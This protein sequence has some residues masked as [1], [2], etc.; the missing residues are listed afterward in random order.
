MSLLFI[1]CP[2]CLLKEF[3]R[4]LFCLCFEGFDL[5][6]GCVQI[7]NICR[8]VLILEKPHVIISRPLAY[9]QIRIQYLADA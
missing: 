6:V 4:E 5:V 9:L 2:F 7:G 3:L 8:F 1:S